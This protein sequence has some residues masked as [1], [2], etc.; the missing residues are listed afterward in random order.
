MIDGFLARKLRITSARGSQ[1]DS[2]G[3]QITF[4]VGLTGLLV[5]EFDFIKENYLLL[6]LIF[7][8]YIVQMLI[9]FRKFG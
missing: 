8:P 3:D 7:I 4:V 6:L 1:L 9:T 5:F 2:L